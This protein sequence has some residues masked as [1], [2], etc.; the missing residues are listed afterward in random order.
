MKKKKKESQAKMK[1]LINKSLLLS[2]NT[3]IQSWTCN[4]L[5]DLLQVMM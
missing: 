3:Q 5:E 4:V 1:K 2:N